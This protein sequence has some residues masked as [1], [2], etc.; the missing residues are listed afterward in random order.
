[1][2]N[3]NLADVLVDDTF[4]FEN[5]HFNMGKM[6]ADG[7]YQVFIGWED[8]VKTAFVSPDEASKLFFNL[9]ILYAFL[10]TLVFAFMYSGLYYLN[11]IVN[12]LSQGLIF[13]VGNSRLLTII[14]IIA[15]SYFPLGVITKWSF[16]I[17]FQDY[18]PADFLDYLT[19]VVEFFD[20][21]WVMVVLGLAVITEVFRQGEELKNEQEFT[22]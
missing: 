14:N 5:I 21:E 16:L 3:W 6:E 4:K 7:N 20:W 8:K 13:N 15:I 22:V 11:K 2:Y 12:N 19:G 1:M 10:T 18:Y 17:F 9:H